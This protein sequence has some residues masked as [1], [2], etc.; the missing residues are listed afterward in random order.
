[1]RKFGLI[2]ETQQYELLSTFTLLVLLTVSS[3]KS[4]EC[5]IQV[6]NRP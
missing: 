6:S 3:S 2:P 5:K 4:K 1:M